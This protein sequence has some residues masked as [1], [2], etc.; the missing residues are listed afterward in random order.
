MAY[1]IQ[2]RGFESESDG[3]PQRGLNLANLSAP[4]APPSRCHLGL[5]QAAPTNCSPII[6]VA[7]CHRAAPNSATAA[8]RR[9]KPAAKLGL[10]APATGE[11]QQAV[12]TPWQQ[13][14][15][16]QQTA[17]KQTQVSASLTHAQQTLSARASEVGPGTCQQAQIR[18]QHL[19]ASSECAQEHRTD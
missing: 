15:T 8:A 12:R 10:A 16:S 3:S 4:A 5:H 11:T 1:S 7:L 6:S 19:Q 17:A 2:T 9:S 14:R 18:V 13:A